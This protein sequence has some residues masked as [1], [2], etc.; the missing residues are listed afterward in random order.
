MASS[1]PQRVEARS[2]WCTGKRALELRP[3]GVHAL[4]ALALRQRYRRAGTCTASPA[5]L[6]RA[7]LSVA[8][9]RSSAWWRRRHAAGARRL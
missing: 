8:S 3:S 1:L 9:G 6:S 5:I 2:R 4:P 7:A